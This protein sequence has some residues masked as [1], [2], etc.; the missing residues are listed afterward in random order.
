MTTALPGGIKAVAFDA[1]GTLLEPNPKPAEVYSA[2][3][4]RHGSKLLPSFVASAFREAFDFQERHDQSLRLATNEARE[5]ER[6][7]TIVGS[8]LH[9]VAD[10]ESCFQELWRHFGQPVNWRWTPGVAEL[11]SALRQ[12]DLKIAIASNFDS[13]LR[14]VL[15]GFPQSRHLHDVVISSEVGW[16]K[17]A[18][19]FFGEVSRRLSCRPAEILFVGDHIGNDYEGARLAGM[20]AVLFDP[21]GKQRAMSLRRME[22]LSDLLADLG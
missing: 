18:R 6:W 8:V 2:I 14:A 5:L 20:Q 13:R 12:R 16:R 10:K 3:G 7:R 22:C 19:E 1:V 4:G 11:F 9:D 15:N 17:P 21:A